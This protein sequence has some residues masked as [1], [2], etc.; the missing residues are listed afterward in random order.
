MLQPAV[1]I[2][3]PTGSV[4]SAGAL[5]PGQE[6]VVQTVTT[7]VSGTYSVVVSSLGGSTGAYEVVATLNAAVESESHTGGTNDA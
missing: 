3:S 1:E 2:I 4:G 7:D 6:A 5:G